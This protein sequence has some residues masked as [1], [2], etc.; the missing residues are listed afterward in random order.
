MRNSNTRSK[1]LK[2]KI[3]KSKKIFHAFSDVQWK[4]V[5]SLEEN[6]EVVEI[7][8]NVK[9]IGLEFGDNYTSDFVCVKSDGQLMIR[10]CVLRKNLLKPTTAKLLDASRNYWLARGNKD[11]GIVIDV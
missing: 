5:E 2:R 10:E 9:L 6:D 11:W 8:F 4:Y 1:T 3:K 7:R